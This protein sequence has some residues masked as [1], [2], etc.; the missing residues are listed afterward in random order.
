MTSNR[1]KIKVEKESHD[2]IVD[3]I[4]ILI[5]IAIWVYPAMNYLNMPDTIPIHFNAKGEA[6]NWGAK[7]FIWML[8]IITT[9]TVGLIMFL[10]QYPHLHNYMVNITEEN[11]YKNYQ[12]ST[13][14]LRYANLY[15][16]LLMIVVTFE[17]VQKA[18]GNDLNI[19][20]IPFLIFTIL[21]PLVGIVFVFIYQQKINK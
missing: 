6:D 8:P 16:V 9:L 20:G 3:I 21:V 14:V 12:L 11:A 13:R 5:L 4:V 10:N 18:L 1:P 2:V 15:V 17:I 19:V 7:N